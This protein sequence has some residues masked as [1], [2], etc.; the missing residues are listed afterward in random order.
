MRRTKSVANQQHVVL[1]NGAS[2]PPHTH[3]TQPRHP[4]GDSHDSNVQRYIQGGI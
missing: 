2:P 3:I 1:D 4:H